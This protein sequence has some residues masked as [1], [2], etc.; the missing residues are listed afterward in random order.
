MEYLQELMCLPG[1]NNSR[2]DRNVWKIKKGGSPGERKD[3][4]VNWQGSFDQFF[5]LLFYWQGILLIKFLCK[6]CTI[7]AVY[8]Y[9]CLS[10]VLAAKHGSNQ[11]KRLSSSTTMPG[12]IFVALSVQKLQ[13]NSRD[14]LIMLPE[15]QT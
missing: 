13:K 12:P 2:K 7:N 1:R 6:R 5:Y 4:S 10:E 11:F 3:L 15:A 14:N 9:E 8:Y